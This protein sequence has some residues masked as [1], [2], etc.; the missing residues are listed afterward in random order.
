[1]THGILPRIG[2]LALLPPVAALL[3]GC[4]SSLQKESY[5]EHLKYPLRADLIINKQSV[6]ETVKKLPPPGDLDEA[7]AA[8]NTDSEENKAV[9]YNPSKLESDD[10]ESIRQA[11]EA[12]FGTPAN[13]RVAMADLESDDPLVNFW[14]AFRRDSFGLAGAGN[15]V[16]D[17]LLDDARLQRGSKL[18]RRHCMH[19]HGVSGDG[20]GPTGP[21]LHPHPRDYRSGL[22]KFVSSFLPKGQRKPRRADLYRILNQGIDGTSMPSFGLL[23]EDEKEYLASYVMHLSIRGEAEYA[24]MTELLSGN[25]PDKKTEEALGKFGKDASRAKHLVYSYAA[26][27][28]VLWAQSNAKAPLGAAAA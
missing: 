11:S 10:R 4:N 18:F 12:L 8:N 6:R 2:V 7:I 20:R 23:P 24:A 9:V 22:F 16:G 15:A 17:L 25:P 3:V 14:W 1:V 5:P 13:P 27:A 28:L 26:A 19:C 21:W